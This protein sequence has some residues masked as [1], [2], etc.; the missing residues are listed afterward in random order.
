MVV[1]KEGLAQRRFITTGPLYDGLRARRGLT[2]EDRVIVTG[3]V[4][5][6]P[7][8]PC[9]DQGSRARQGL[10]RHDEFSKIF[11]DRPIFASVLPSSLCS[12]ERSPTVPSD[13]GYPEVAPPT[14]VVRA[15]YPGGVRR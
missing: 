6:R 10:I 9:Q 2:P 1:D 5:V 11:I 7:G 14:I 8:M 12:W 15:S 13:C 3:L 4:R